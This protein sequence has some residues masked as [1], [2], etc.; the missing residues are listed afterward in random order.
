MKMANKVSAIITKPLKEGKGRREGPETLPY[1][2]D[3]GQ[4]LYKNAYFML[5]ESCFWCCTLYGELKKRITRT[6]PYCLNDRLKLMH[7]LLNEIH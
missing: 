1:N 2:K 6:C 4:A 5:C 7:I 3:N